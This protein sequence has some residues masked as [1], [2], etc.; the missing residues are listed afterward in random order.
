MDSIT[1]YDWSIIDRELLAA[2]TALAG[3]AVVNQT[4]TPVEFTTKI[5]Q[6]LRF[7]KIPVNVVSSYHKQTNKSEIWV[8][9]LY[10]SVKDQSGLRSITLRLQYNPTDKYVKIKKSHF[11]RFCISVADT[12]LHEIIHMRQYRRRNFKDIPGYESVA[13][14]SR[15]RVEQTYLGHNDEIDAYSFNIACMLDVSFR[16]NSDKI[17]NYLNKNLSDRR[18]KRNPYLLYLKTFDHDHNHIVIKK[19]KK[20]IMYYLPYAKLGKPYKTSSWL[21]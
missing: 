8:G 9:G 12:V 3:Y 11:N 21:K 14:S 7:F 13:E 20:K 5:R 1:Q 19:L 18:L 17:I 6:H 2:I 16:S 15:Q 4:L 10:D